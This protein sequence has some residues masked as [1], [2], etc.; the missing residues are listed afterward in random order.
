MKYFIVLER[1][2]HAE[3]GKVTGMLL[4]MDQTK[5]LHLVEAPEALKKKVEEALN[6]L[7]T[8]VR[9]KQTRC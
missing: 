4:D 9:S 2:E 6:V 7:G 5:F 3:A 8:R 1:I